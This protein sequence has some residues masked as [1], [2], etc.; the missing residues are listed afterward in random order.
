M[1]FGTFLNPKTVSKLATGFYTGASARIGAMLIGRDV[2]KPV[3]EGDGDGG[4]VGRQGLSGDC[5][6]SFRHKP[7]SS[8]QGV[9]IP[10]FRRARCATGM[11]YIY[12]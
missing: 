4:V 10:G 9:H 2:S 3:I 8:Q 12:K 7:E 5:G 1:L 11:T 6:S